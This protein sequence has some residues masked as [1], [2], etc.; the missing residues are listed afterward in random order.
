MAD[1]LHSEDS[2]DGSEGWMELDSHWTP[3]QRSCISGLCLSVKMD[4]DEDGGEQGSRWHG[5]VISGP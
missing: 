2:S 1:G 4:E 3:P 5:A